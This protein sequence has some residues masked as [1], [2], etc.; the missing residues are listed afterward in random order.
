MK[1]WKFRGKSGRSAAR[2][3]SFG[4][5]SS[6]HSLSTK[7][8]EVEVSWG[9]FLSISQIQGKRVKKEV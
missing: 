6:T 9:N 8:E 3:G 2:S 7:V 4:T 5:T 1:W